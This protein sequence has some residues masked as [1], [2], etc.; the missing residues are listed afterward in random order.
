VSAE[1]EGDVTAEL[2]TN[3]N[4]GKTIT[5]V[6]PAWRCPHHDINGYM[7]HTKEKDKKSVAQN[8]GVR[9]EGIDESTRQTKTYFG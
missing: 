2:G 3:C 4:L 1:S 9:Y 7:F 6:C 8:S 5:S